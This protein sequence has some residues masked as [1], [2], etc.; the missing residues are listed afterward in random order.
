MSLLICQR[1][2]EFSLKILLGLA[3]C[4]G[5]GGGIALSTPVSPRVVSL[6]PHVTELIFAAGA[7]HTI[8]ATVNASDYPEAALGIDRIGDGLNTSAEQVLA[9]QPDWV[10]GWPSA[11][12][13][14]LQALGVETVVLEPS[15]IIQIAQQVKALGLLL[16]TES[17]ANTKSQ[18]ITADIA[19]IAAQV[20][21]RS[22]PPLPVVVLASPDG[23]YVLGRQALINDALALCGAQNVFA[24]TLSV[25]P[26][27]SLE[28]LIA[29][30]PALVITGYEPSAW[31]GD[32]FNVAVINPS[33]LYRPGPRFVQATRRICAAV[34]QARQSRQ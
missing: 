18:E 4:L 21:D 20:T 28:G 25:A 9:L 2:T 15:T 30:K 16:G 22:A 10:M 23:Q 7:G 11:L 32:Q 1:V 17:V 33:W 31:L 26:S 3:L 29:A 24:E 6:T 8:V 27:V 5:L 34:K 19:L 12:M 14:Q 13:T